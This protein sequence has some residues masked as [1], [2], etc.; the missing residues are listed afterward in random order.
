MV[1]AQIQDGGVS[2][3]PSLSLFSLYGR[4]LLLMNL[5][6][7]G[8]SGGT[9]EPRSHVGSRSRAA[10]WSRGSGAKRSVSR[11]QWQVDTPR[12]DWLAGVMSRMHV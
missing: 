5:E 2:T 11:A 12:P 6:A 3:S 10:A 1:T 7:L 8:C 9:G 4:T